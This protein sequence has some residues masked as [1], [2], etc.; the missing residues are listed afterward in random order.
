MFL[1]NLPVVLRM[2]TDPDNL[3]FTRQLLKTFRQD[4]GYS[5]FKYLRMFAAS[6][7]GE[8][9]VRFGRQYVISSY[10]PA[11]PSRAFLSF[12]GGAQTPS[13]SF[14]DL[15]WVRRRAP[16]ST[17]L[18]ITDRCTYN[19]FHCSARV[20]EPGPELVTSQWIKIIADLQELGTAYIGFTG[21]EPL[22]RKD[23]EE[24]IASIDDRSSSI[25]FTNGRGLTLERAR[26][27]KRRGLF[28]LSVSLDSADA[29]TH[30]R[31]RNDPDAFS[32]A[33]Q[34]IRNSRQA[35][36]YTIVQAVVFRGELTRRKLF[37][38][39]RL[40]KKH[41]AHE[42]RIHQPV[43]AG[44]LLLKDDD[45]F[46]TDA[47]RK[48]L[49]AVQFAANRRLWGFPKVSSFP[50]TEG[51]EKFGCSAGILHSYITASG[52]FC[53]CD[54]V[55]LSFGN[56]LK[57]DLAELYRRMSRATGIPRPG[58][59]AVDIADKL[60]GRRL[61]LRARESIGLC[62]SMQSSLYPGFYRALQFTM[63]PVAK[64]V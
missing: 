61:P 21:G 6:V 31:M 57:T 43:P 41:G 3:R 59:W 56:V 11:V 55:P 29:E 14:S 64:K 40:V 63:K 49:F 24:I 52:E 17:Y 37:D 16:L 50:Y 23:L 45:I 36:L 27:L 32:S 42:I 58:C 4:P 12:L 35:G 13:R 28:A 30:N 34:A 60:R 18:G 51:P 48:R 54:F 38:L 26:C 7:R 25:L 39:F 47:D 1:S 53:P 9:I 10:V 8:R 46:Y 2:F 22:L 20:G 33:L 44:R 62:H 5:F 15:A 19:C